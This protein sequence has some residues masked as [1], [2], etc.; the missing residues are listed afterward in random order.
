M[1][2]TPHLHTIPTPPHDN[3]TEKALLGYTIT[4]PHTAPT[5]TNTI[6]P[7][8][9]YNPTHETIWHTITTLVD[10][11]HTPDHLT[12]LHHL[13][14]G[15]RVDHA[16][17]LQLRDYADLITDPKTATDHLNTTAR[18]RH[19][20]TALTAAQHRLTTTDDPTGALEQAMDALE[21]GLRDT[22]NPGTSTTPPTTW[23]P[24]DLT[25]VLAGE[26][27]DPPPTILRRADGQ[28]LIY[29]G[30]VHTISGES[31]SGKTWLTLL[32]ALQELQD[33]NGVTFI[34]FEDR[35]DRVIARLLA[36][37]ATPT[38]IRDNFAYV[39]PDRPLDDTGRK[40]L[41]PHLTGRKLVI[42]DGVTEAMTIHGYDLNSNSD[43]ALFY[44]LL[45]R[46]IADQGPAVILI[47][48]VVKDREQQG[49]FAIG[50]QHKLAGI[51]GAAY[52]VKVLMPFSRGKRG[53]ARVDV[54]KDRPG[55]VR[56]YAHGKTIA[57]FTL[58]AT[59]GDLILQAHLLPTND[60]TNRGDAFEPTHLMEKISRY[61]QA[62]PGLS[63]K[64]L[65]AQLNGKTDTKRLALELLVTRGYVGTKAG[66]RGV[67][68]H[69]HER[70]YYA[71]PDMNTDPNHGTDD[72]T[73]DCS[74]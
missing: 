56:E 64:A 53:I 58:D 22:Y 24:V 3:T 6:R 43:A 55:H 51:D 4:N 2:E 19:A 30:A 23:A 25:P 72:T 46:W 16:Q 8:A 40:A 68:Q 36:L 21:Q 61:V 31:E 1:T 62:N 57:E 11:G 10:Q 34:D 5:L 12:V 41:T 38:Q 15:A 14:P 49:R 67:V 45:P 44:G 52:T 29:D 48:H 13:P 71:D 9:F 37:G 66:P 50:A 42:L 54:S 39:R 65:E 35:A 7:D 26:H 47:D 74:A 32:A 70:P 27:L 69:F 60:H 18:R 73:E 28:P 33:N 59:A 20:T 17:L 63:K